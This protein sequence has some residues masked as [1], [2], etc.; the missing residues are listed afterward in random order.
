[1]HFPRVITTRHHW[2]LVNN[3][4]GNGLVHSGTKPQSQC[5]PR[6]M[7]PYSVATPQWVNKSWKHPWIC[8]TMGLISDCYKIKGEEEPIGVYHRENKSDPQLKTHFSSWNYILTSGHTQQYESWQPTCT[9]I[10][11]IQFYNPPLPMYVC[12]I[13]IDGNDTPQVLNGPTLRCN[14]HIEGASLGS[15]PDKV[16]KMFSQNRA[17]VH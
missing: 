14:Q 15:W 3:V 13:T 2:W 12:K 5:R 6:S 10:L 9:S 11:S 16:Y 7:L 8:C 4:S 17:S 1:M